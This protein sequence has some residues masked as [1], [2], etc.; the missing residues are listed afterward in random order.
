MLYKVDES[1]FRVWGRVIFSFWIANTFMML[2]NGGAGE[3]FACM[4]LNGYMMGMLRNPAAALP[5]GYEGT[6]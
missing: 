5:E 6:A 3:F 2:M 4:I 1:G